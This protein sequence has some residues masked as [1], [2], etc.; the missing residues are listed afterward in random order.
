MEN[1][2][3]ENR[4]ERKSEVVSSLAQSMT[5]R[6]AMMKPQGAAA[7]PEGKRARKNTDQFVGRRKTSVA[8][9]ALKA[10]SGVITINKRKLDEYFTRA[11]LRAAVLRP[12]MVTEQAGKF[13][14]KVNVYGGGITGQAKAISLGIAR[15]IDQSDSTAHSKLKVAGLLTRDSRMVERK[16]YGLHKARRATQ[17]SKR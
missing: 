14:I 4:E 12:L 11:D 2:S 17:F 9:V 7:K 6:K 5:R 16:K 13:D 15:S 10:G 8:R 3:P 1:K